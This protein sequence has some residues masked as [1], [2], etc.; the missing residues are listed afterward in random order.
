MTVEDEAEPEAG[1]ERSLWQLPSD[2]AFSVMS[3]G[4]VPAIALIVG[5]DVV[6]R[7][8]FS[9]PIFWAQDVNTL[10]LLLLFFCGQ[11]VCLRYGDHVRMEL[12][13]QRFPVLLKRAVDSLSALMAVFIAW[14][15]GYRLWREMNDPFA[16]GDT[17]GFIKFPVMPVRIVLL[18]VLALVFLEAL[19][20]LI[21]AWRS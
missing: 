12:L 15:I 1:E 17:H 5:A 20:R 21:A 9:A 19:R 3:V 2:L 10:L 14:T 13:Y 4:V 8:V 18:I 7:Y 6:A 16:A 11:P